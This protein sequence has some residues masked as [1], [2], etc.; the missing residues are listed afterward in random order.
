MSFNNDGVYIFQQKWNETSVQYSKFQKA[1]VHTGEVIQKLILYFDKLDNFDSGYK[2][3]YKNC[4]L[5]DD[6]EEWN[7]SPEMN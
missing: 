3:Y 2:N 4:A 5:F 7:A 1:E 6:F